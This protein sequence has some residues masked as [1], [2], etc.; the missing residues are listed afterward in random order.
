MTT[1]EPAL[2]NCGEWLPRAWGTS[3]K[4]LKA[5]SASSGLEGALSLTEPRVAMLTTLGE[6]RLTM[7]ASVGIGA[8][9][10]GVGAAGTA[11]GEL[12]AAGVRASA[13]GPERTP[14]AASAIG[15]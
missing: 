10:A 7:G 8:S 1:P 5:G 9:S 4:R 6:T 11:A 2:W 3:K 12:P 14:S 15:P 13:G